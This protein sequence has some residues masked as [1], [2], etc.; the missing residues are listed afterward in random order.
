MITIPINSTPEILYQELQ[1]NI[2][3]G[4]VFISLTTSEIGTLFYG[5]VLQ[6]GFMCAYQETHG[7]SCRIFSRPDMPREDVIQMLSH[8]GPYRASWIIIPSKEGSIH[9][10]KKSKKTKKTKKS[11]GKKKRTKKRRCNRKK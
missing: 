5:K 1:K 11:K 2:V 7:P 3:P 4:F 6:S 10:G 9:G 8:T